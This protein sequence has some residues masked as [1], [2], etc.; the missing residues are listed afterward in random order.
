MSR[1][2]RDGL[3]LIEVLV[4]IAIL[5]ILIGLFL[6][7]TRKVRDASARTQSQSNLK[8]IGIALANY[9]GANNG[10][11]P[12]LVTDSGGPPPTGTAYPVSSY[13][14]TLLA[15]CE[16]NY[17]IFQAPL[18]PKLTSARLITTTVISVQFPGGLVSAP[19]SYGWP[20]AWVTG[21]GDGTAENPYMMLPD[22]FK[23]R[24]TANC[25]GVAETSTIGRD[26]V[27]ACTPFFG[28][29]PTVIDPVTTV[30]T[31][32]SP[33]GQASCFSSSGCQVTMMDGSVKNVPPSVRATDWLAGTNPLNPMPFSPSW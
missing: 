23:L 29:P 6:P 1:S 24:G 27:S 22:S 3:T 5:A 16:N 26:L 15:F 4:V 33:T 9:A 21:T 7:A 31:L 25:I 14:G 32:T 12:F 18:D 19:I 11:L 28:S 8:Q 17:K 10:K 20:G 2:T 13:F 30:V